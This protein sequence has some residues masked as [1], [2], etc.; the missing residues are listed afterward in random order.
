MDE[1]KGVGRLT[2]AELTG[3]L[4]KVPAD[5]KVMSNSGWECD[6]TDIGGI[7]YNRERNEV[8]LTQ[9]GYLEFKHGYIDGFETIYCNTDDEEFWTKCRF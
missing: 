2:A 8:H 4:Q 5:C 6:E 9:G 3:W 7:Y 1:T